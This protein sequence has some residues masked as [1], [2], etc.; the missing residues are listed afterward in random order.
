MTTVATPAA[1]IPSQ[2]TPKKPA[3]PWFTGDVCGI[4]ARLRTAVAERPDGDCV[5]AVVYIEAIQEQERLSAPRKGQL[6]AAVLQALWMVRNW[7][8]PLAEP[9]ADWHPPAAELSPLPPP[10]AVELGQ[11]VPAAAATGAGQ[12]D[13][14]LEP[15]VQELAAVER[16]DV[17]A[18]A[19]GLRVQA[20]A[21]PDGECVRA[22]AL[23][24]AIH[25][26]ESLPAAVQAARTVAVIAAV[27]EVRGWLP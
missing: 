8:A 4:A 3:L 23:I 13:A 25:D 19:R 9:P 24:E 12:A 14:A 10:P 21:R 6:T 2:R 15:A 16:G 1:V 11:D 20:R 22:I 27:R 18:I 26:D 17:E 7:D 5:Q